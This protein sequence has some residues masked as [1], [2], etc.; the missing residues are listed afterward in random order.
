MMKH[1]YPYTVAAL[2]EYSIYF[3]LAV[4]LFWAVDCITINQVITE[5]RNNGNKISV[6]WKGSV[7]IFIKK[8]VDVGQCF[9][10][11]LIL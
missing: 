8:F 1:I 11:L 6:G 3:I 5:K 2:P 9:K 4:V 7:K 10:T